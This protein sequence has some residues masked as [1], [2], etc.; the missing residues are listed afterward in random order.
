MSSSKSEGESM[1]I[2][3]LDQKLDEQSREI[4]ILEA[5]LNELEAKGKG[6][7]NNKGYKDELMFK[8]IM[9]GLLATEFDISSHIYNEMQRCRL[10]QPTT[11]DGCQ[12]DSNK[13]E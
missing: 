5:R 12:S 9:R 7:N 3:L 13:L 8:E 1:I 4:E 2:N 6:N 10:S 11:I